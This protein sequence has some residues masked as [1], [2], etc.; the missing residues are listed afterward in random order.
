MTGLR[1]MRYRRPRWF[2]RVVRHALLLAGLVGVIAA[3]QLL[4]L[5][6]LGRL[7]T[8]EERAVL[9]GSTIA[10][11]VAALLYQPVRCAA[12]GGSGPCWFPANGTG[13]RAQRVGHGTQP[14]R[15]A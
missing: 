9:L 1:L 5:L 2:D 12:R 3:V 14:R 11:A 10:A 8:D 6:V 15:T 7:P 4:V 13:R